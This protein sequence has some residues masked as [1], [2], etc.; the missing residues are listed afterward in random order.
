M[1][2]ARERARMQRL[3]QYA[4][5]NRQNPDLFGWVQIEGTPIDY[6]VMFTPD[7][8]EHYLHRDFNGSYSSSGVPFLDADCKED[9]NLYLVYG[10]HMKNGSMFATLGKYDSSQYWEE[11]PVILFDTL[12]ET[13]D[14]EIMAAFYAKVT[15]AGSGGFQYYDYTDLSDPEVFDE[16][17]S[18]VKRLSVIDTGITA[19]YGDRLVTL[20][21]CSYHTSDGRFVVVG[22]QKAG[23]RTGQKTK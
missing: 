6:P 17:V 16:Y 18:N 21:T 15:G 9:G 4:A 3:I 23:D 10:H 22:R 11:H 13:G 20:S 2:A 12:T 19:E 7:D 5:L 1:E 14:Y 8:P